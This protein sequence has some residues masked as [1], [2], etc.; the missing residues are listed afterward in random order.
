MCVSLWAACYSP[1]KPDC[2]FVCGPGGACPEQYH[3]AIDNHC[4]LDGTSDSMRCGSDAGIDFLV[5]DGA[6]PDTFDVTLPMVVST[7]PM[8][9]AI[10]VP[11]TTT[12]VVQFSEVV[13]NVDLTSFAVAEGANAIAGQVNGLSASQYEFT[14]SAD[15]PNN[16]TITV[17]LSAAISDFVGNPL[18]NAPYIFTFQTMN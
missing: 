9:Q 1:P 16:R 4:H 17:T 7:M 13:V 11:V 2:G 14:P 3:C 10:D 18:A 8:D 12:I 6:P 5:I 15:L